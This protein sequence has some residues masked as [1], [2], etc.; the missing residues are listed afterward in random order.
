MRA[1]I[2][3][4]YEE[5]LMPAEIAETLEVPVATVKSNLHRGL[6]LLRRNV[7]RALKYQHG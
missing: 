1:V 3:L 5:D 4:R 2:V 6:Q 7:E